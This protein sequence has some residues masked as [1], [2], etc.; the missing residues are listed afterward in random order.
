MKKIKVGDIVMVTPK[1][2]EEEGGLEWT[3]RHWA[4][5]GV[6]VRGP[7][8]EYDYEVTVGDDPIDEECAFYESEVT[9]LGLSVV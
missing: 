9:P 8:L 7:V 3:D 4:R 6:V 1:Y 5:W 2:T